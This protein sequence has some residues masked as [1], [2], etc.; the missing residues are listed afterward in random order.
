MKLLK[1][2]LALIAIFTV[3][4]V[5]AKRENSG[6]REQQPKTN[7]PAALVSARKPVP[8]T[9][10]ASTNR[11]PAKR[12]S[13]TAKES[14]AR[15]ESFSYAE[16]L[17]AIKRM[18]SDDVID[19]QGN[20]Q[21]PF[22]DFV[23]KKEEE[24]EAGRTWVETSLF[25]GLS[26]HGDALDKDDY[27][28]AFANNKSSVIQATNY[29]IDIIKA[30]RIL[31]DED[32]PGM[33]QDNPREL[34][35]QNPSPEQVATLKKEENIW[36]R[37][38]ATI[39]ADYL[40]G[41]INPLI[42]AGKSKE[43]I[44]DIIYKELKDTNGAQILLR[45]TSPRELEGSIKLQIATER[46]TLIH[47]RNQSRP[48]TPKPVI[49]EPKFSADNPV[50]IT[51][52]PDAVIVDWNNSKSTPEWYDSA[53]GLFKKDWLK[54]RVEK[55]VELKLK[56]P[57]FSS[58]SIADQR[59]YI[60]DT[61]CTPELITWRHLYYARPGA[62]IQTRSINDNN[63]P[64]IN[65]VEEYVKS[66]LWDQAVLSHKAFLTNSSSKF[67]KMIQGQQSAFDRLL[68]Q[69][70]SKSTQTKFPVWYDPKTELLNEDW[71]EEQIKKVTF[72][73]EHRDFLSLPIGSPR[74]EPRK[75][76]IDAV[77]DN[78]IKQYAS[79]W[80]D[81]QTRKN[82]LEIKDN[83]YVSLT[84]QIGSYISDNESKVFPEKQNPQQS[85]S[86][87]DRLLNS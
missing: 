22:I 51:K 6:K 21:K 56:D 87:F 64:L 41:R 8:Q 78:Y 35:Q 79:Q 19:A 32:L 69:N 34:V 38:D 52:T 20:L 77:Y 58:K 47:Q 5:S 13:R 33:T 57:N 40:K 72:L 50:T 54:N 17:N 39:S 80:Q 3:T 36:P 45:G 86:A 82:S 10:P 46:E 48:L 60:V 37:R 84:E 76:I 66:F 9:K 1:N 29:I 75:K 4:A 55:L 62:P 28:T 83:R 14:V 27:R 85:T 16:M 49:A 65:Q 70:D 68:Q 18:N 67:N 31:P 2:S 23:M 11:T 15:E 74:R 71:L 24:H 42:D 53:T 12:S 7:S 61:V 73:P 63:K 59:K 43:E 25:A 44:L 81:L 30:R 26:L